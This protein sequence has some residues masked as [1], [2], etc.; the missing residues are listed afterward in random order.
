MWLNDC[1]ALFP[2]MTRLSLGRE[3]QLDRLERAVR[4]ATD[5]TITPH[6]LEIIE[7]SPSWSYPAWWPKLSQVLSTTIRLPADLESSDGAVRQVVEQ[8][9]AQLKHIEVVS[10]VLRFVEPRTFGIFSPPVTAFLNLAPTGD[11]VGYY[12]RYLKNLKAL[13]AHYRV[14]DRMA[15]VDMALWVAAHLAFHEKF[16]PLANEVNRDEFFQVFRLRNL[17]AGIRRAKPSDVSWRMVFAQALLQRDHVT[18]ALV[19]A[20][21]YEDLIW[22]VSRVYG[23]KLPPDPSRPAD[24]PRLI[25]AIAADPFILKRLK[26]DG[27]DLR[28]LWQMR[29]GAIH[30]EEGLPEPEARRFVMAVA[31]LWRSFAS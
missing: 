9:M 18:A 28:G 6:V 26:V 7:Q 19:T 14:L 15:D 1:L 21:S 4:S 27:L 13:L 2:E 29:N 12:L 16:A 30:D 25:N 8:V 10:V 22:H 3:Q 24:C 31:D 20:R 5:G 11:H 23:I 17:M